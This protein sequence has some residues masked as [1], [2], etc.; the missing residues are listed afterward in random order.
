[1]KLTAEAKNAKDLLERKFNLKL[2]EKCRNTPYIKAR[3]LFSKLMEKRGFGCFAISKMLNLNHATILNYFNNFEWFY[4]ID[5]DFAE[6]YEQIY[7]Q[8][9][10]SSIIYTQMNE[11]ELKKELILLQ[12]ENKNLY[13]R[14]RELELKVK[15]LKES[16]VMY[17]ESKM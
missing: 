13:L 4:K 17:I 2:T 5:K 12:K 3:C 14:N 8:M 10:S 16:K 15:K 6:T 7:E 9:Q 1:M 11:F